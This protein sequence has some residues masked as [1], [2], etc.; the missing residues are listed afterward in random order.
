MDRTR[1]PTR[2]AALAAL[3]ALVAAACGSASAEESR[4]DDGSI[5]QRYDLSGMTYTV[6]SKNFTE[7]LVLGNIARL[8]LQAAGAEV[9][10]EIG[11][12]G[13]AA[14]RSALTSGAIDLYWEYNGTGWITHLGHSGKD[15]PEQ[16]TRAVNEQDLERNRIRWLPSAPF[17]N[18]YALAVR[19]EVQDELGVR[20]ISD[21]GR[22]IEER[23]G[24]ATLCV[25]SEFSVRNDGLPGLE[26]A[27][28]FEVPD[29][30][31][32]LMATGL[33]YLVTDKGRCNFG[34]VF[35]SDGRIKGLGLAV[36]E[37]DQGFFP[38]YNPSVTI[39]EQVYQ[40][41][42]E[43]GRLFGEIASKLSL[44]EMRELNARVDA[45]GE[46]PDQVA[47]DWLRQNGFI[48]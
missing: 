12:A 41:R 37:D 35:A 36:L 1:R 44:D 3:L 33:V 13:T 11:L 9:S 14:A 16:L 6:G 40:Q 32:F 28:G 25:E 46:F 8:A 10:D 45:E 22:L 39:R 34:E 21:L 5:G 48:G 24:Q 20:K 30:N 7:Q 47:E 15:L 19:Q 31:V 17:D 2:L 38:P 18:T 42:P 27:Y 4:L 43:V 26:Q 29:R 23:P